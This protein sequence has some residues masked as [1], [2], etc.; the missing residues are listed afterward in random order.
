MPRSHA[1]LHAISL[2]GLLIIQDTR[3]PSQH[4]GT[5]SPQDRL[6]GAVTSYVVQPGDSLTLLAARHGLYVDTLARQNGLR[7]NARLVSG[8]L[9]RIDNRHILP[10]AGDASI[11]INIPQRMLF[12][13]HQDGMV[14][15]YPV[16]IGR[17]DWPTPVGVF[18]IASKVKDPTWHVPP[19]IQE[20]IRQSGR[21]P[22]FSV[23]PGPSNPLGDRWVGTTLANI[24][25]HGTNAPLTIFGATTHGCVRLHS[26]DIRELFD[27]VALDTAGEI[28][29]QPV[30]ITESAGQIFVEAHPDVYRHVT[31]PL[32]AIR[33][34]AVRDGF[35]EL[36]DWSSA[37]HAIEDQAGVA[38]DVTKVESGRH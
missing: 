29:Y 37:E 23:P 1:L 12:W 26:D 13:R 9:L 34:I 18:T 21:V 38:C 11:I 7:P 30:L 24:G 35:D 31:N 36:V 28:V 14:R 22:P 33:R 27:E 16:A 19:S 2:S 17:P 3:T 20:E 4:P 5:I 10:D 6:A 15:G 8:R 25:I 32:E